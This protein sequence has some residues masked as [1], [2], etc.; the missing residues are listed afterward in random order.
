MLGIAIDELR[1][2]I[3]V[4]VDDLGQGIERVAGA[5]PAAFS[6]FALRGGGRDLA[7]LRRRTAGRPQTLPPAERRRGRLERELRGIIEAVGAAAI[8]RQPAIDGKQE[9]DLAVAVDVDRETA[10]GERNE[11]L[12]EKSDAGF[13]ARSSSASS[14]PGPITISPSPS[15]VQ[16]TKAALRSG[17]LRSHAPT[18][19]SSSALG[20]GLEPP[21][22]ATAEEEQL[23]PV[24]QG[25]NHRQDVD[26]GARVV[27]LH[28]LLEP[29]FGPGGRSDH[30]REVADAVAVE[31]D[32]QGLDRNARQ[33]ETLGEQGH[34]RGGS[35]DGLRP[36][37]SGSDDQQ[38]GK[39]PRKRK[40]G[41][42]TGGGLH[43]RT[44]SR[45]GDPYTA[46]PAG[47]RRRRGGWSPG[48][49]ARR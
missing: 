35:E 19:R 41:A 2:A 26:E 9:I 30:H 33:L 11:L 24:E 28:L 3:A 13:A 39:K 15:S 47:L 36:V 14:S 27:D 46:A 43:E 49:G 4:E 25:R 20:S 32:I 48:R 23:A 31:I 21:G 45:G 42:L 44:T 40:S 8:E 6:V 16:A 37:E 34:P 17:P 10:S 38:Q 18:L 5:A 7:C 1:P 29:G 22:R 12:L